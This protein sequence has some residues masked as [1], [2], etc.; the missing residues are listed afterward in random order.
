MTTS[1]GVPLHPPLQSVLREHLDDP[2]TVIGGL[3]IPLE[4]AVGDLESSI[5]LVGG[6]LVGGEDPE[7]V[8]VHL[9]NGF[10][11]F[12]DTTVS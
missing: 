8:G 2:T 10:D 3:G 6:E 7:R 11:K 4:V 1:Q 12:A 9:D 5:E